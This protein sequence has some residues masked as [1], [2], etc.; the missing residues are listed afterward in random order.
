MPIVDPQLSTGHAL[1][2]RY[3]SDADGWTT[4]TQV[5]TGPQADAITNYSQLTVRFEAVV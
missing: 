1:I 2:Y 3:G 5:L 4:V